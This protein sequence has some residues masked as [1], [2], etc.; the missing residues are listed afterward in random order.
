MDN[1]AYEYSKKSNILFM[2]DI[3]NLQIKKY[4]SDLVNY[5]YIIDDDNTKQYKW[6]K[7]IKPKAAFLKFRPPYSP[8]KTKYF[9][10]KIYLQ[11][12]SPLSTET[13]LLVFNYDKETEYDNTEF[14]EKLNHFNCIIRQNKNIKSEW[15]NIME[16]NKIKYN[17][18]N[19]YAFYVISYYLDKIKNIKNENETLK[20]FNNIIKYLKLKYGKKYDVIYEN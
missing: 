14:D 6:V 7:I 11:A 17:W 20:L 2:S 1:D 10:G 16:K 4:D 5:D 15:K 9:N 12:Y 19:I 3:R 13:R 8:G 18:D